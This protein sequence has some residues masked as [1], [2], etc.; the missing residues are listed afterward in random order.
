MDASLIVEKF[1]EK[2]RG[3]PLLVRSP[4]RINLIGEHTDYN[5]GWVLP[6]AINKEIVLALTHN[7]SETCNLFSVDLNEECSFSL[8]DIARSPI[9]WANY[10]IGVVHQ[11]KMEGHQVKGFDCAFGGDIPIGSGLSSSA[12]LECGIGF[13]LQRLFKLDLDPMQIVKIGHRSEN[14]FVGLKCGI[15]DQF[16]SVFGK[17]GHFLQLDCRSL[18]YTRVPVDFNGHKLI[19]FNSRVKHD[20]AS[21]EYNVRHQECAQAVC[22]LKKY[23]P[24]INSIR[25]CLPEMIEQLKSDGLL[26]LYHRSKFVVEENCRVIEGVE[27][28]T[29]GRFEEF[30]EKMYQCHRGLSNLYEVSCEELDLLV[31]LTTKREGVLGSRM[32]GGGFG[33]CTIN[34]VGEKQNIDELIESVSTAYKSETGLDLIDYQVAIAD[35]T[36]QI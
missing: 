8:S 19:L 14:D 24:Q 17:A 9:Q 33:G 25:D 31:D 15:M 28:L 21:S 1:K 27:D 13:G 29:A 36:A 30:G 5:Q 10:I 16:A 2:F 22:H 7:D 23:Y 11:L 20:L 4:G 32:M 35:G 18:D 6:A 26:T 12:A 3:H 34:L